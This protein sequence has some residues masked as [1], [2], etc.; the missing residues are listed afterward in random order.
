MGMHHADGYSATVQGFLVVD[1]R[2]IRV[3]K[4]NEALITL[5][6]RCE[7][8]PGTEGELIVTVDGNSFSQT[9]RLPSGMSLDQS[10][11]DYTVAAPF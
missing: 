9:I 6:D 11:T 2:R 5:A 1:G 3:A 10:T 4:T 8:P 7:L